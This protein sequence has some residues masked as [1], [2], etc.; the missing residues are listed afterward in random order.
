MAEGGMSSSPH[1]V[2]PFPSS[3]FFLP[4]S[5]EGPPKDG[6]VGSTGGEREVAVYVNS[7]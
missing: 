4:L 3:H 6:K 5:P 7:L 1:Q 2:S